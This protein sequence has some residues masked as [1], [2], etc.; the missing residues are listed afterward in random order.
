MRTWLILLAGPIVWTVHFFG[1]YIL[2]S[3][4]PGTRAAPLLVL[5]ATGIALALIT[6]LIRRAAR[7]LKTTDDGFARWALQLSLLASALSFVAIVYQAM[8]ALVG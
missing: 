7:S 8:P 2:A 4:L 1:L 6:W 3:I 5:A